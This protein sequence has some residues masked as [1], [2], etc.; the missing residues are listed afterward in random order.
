MKEITTSIEL[1]EAIRTLEAE[2]LVEEK[3]LKA[4]MHAT[5]EAVQPLNFIKSTLHQV[6]GSEEIRKTLLN[7]TIGMSI[8]LLSEKVLENKSISPIQKIA[9]SLILLSITE[10]VTQHPNEVK[11]IG[12]RFFGLLKFGINKINTLHDIDCEYNY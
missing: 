12:K 11:A 4:K 3:A 9:G 7:T 5:Y 8:G 1:Q 2:Y 10:A 6:A